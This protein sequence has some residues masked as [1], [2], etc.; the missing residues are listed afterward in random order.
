MK[1]FTDELIVDVLPSTVTQRVKVSIA[2]SVQA[3]ATVEKL[4]TPN[5]PPVVDAGIDWSITLP[6][7]SIT[8][9]PVVSDPD[10]TNV[11]TTV[12]KLSGPAATIN[13][14]T[15]DNL[16][17]GTYI[18]T[19]TATDDKGAF[20]FDNVAVTVLP[21]VVTPPPAGTLDLLGTFENL[22]VTGRDDIALDRGKLL[23]KQACCSHSVTKGTI[24]RKGTGSLRLE[25]KRTDKAVSNRLRA[26]V[27]ANSQS[28]LEE[29]IGFSTFFENY[30]ADDQPEAFF[31]YHQPSTQGSPPFALWLRNGYIEVLRT[32]SKTIDGGWEQNPNRAGWYVQLTGQKH[33][34]NKWIDFVVHIK[35]STTTT[36][37]IEIWQD[38]VKVFSRMNV[39][40]DYEHIGDNEGANYLKIGV[41]KW[42]WPDNGVASITNRV[43]YYDQLRRFYGTNGFDLVNPAQ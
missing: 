3:T 21:E 10:S 34:I 13:G 11:T 5:K 9:S 7:K 2:G 23:N 22:V 15:V 28:G 31:Q 42:K 35:W 30:A 26:E 33:P 14:L 19:I 25:L 41:Y 27:T 6:K 29:W 32:T 20:S 39:I 37:L 1:N 12:T 36:G 4:E 18:F 24:A 38:G 43:L 17:V 16:V 40:T 8:F